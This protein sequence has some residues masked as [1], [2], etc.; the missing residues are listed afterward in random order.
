[1]VIQFQSNYKEEKYMKIPFGLADFTIGEGATAI[2]FDG[3]ENFQADGGEVSIEPILQAVNVADFGASDY[4]DFVNGFTGTVTIVGAEHSL[5]LME[6]AMAYADK[7][8]DAGTPAVT[9]G[10]TD[11]KI[12]TS[13]RSRGTKMTIHPRE[14]GA[15]K[16][17]D[18]V[19][20]KVAS[21]GAYTRSYANEQGRNELSFKMYPKDGAS[22][23]KSGNFFY[24]GATDPNLP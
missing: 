16:S 21:V 20:Y 17:N 1:V 18:I 9:K 6:T 22:A 15:D 23:A 3:L 10:L 19:L 13:M 11:S 14:M 2:K 12:G 4:D 8:V 24:V 5:K 7:I